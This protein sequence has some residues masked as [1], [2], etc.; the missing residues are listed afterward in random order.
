VLLKSQFVTL[1]AR[2][3]ENDKSKNRGVRCT[4]GSIG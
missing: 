3:K 4:Y 2:A 1:M